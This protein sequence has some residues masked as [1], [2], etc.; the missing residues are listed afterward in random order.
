[1]PLIEITNE[2]SLPIKRKTRGGDPVGTVIASWSCP[3]GSMVMASSPILG[4]S[5]RVEGGFARLRPHQD[6]GQ[7]A[8]VSFTHP[9]AWGRPRVW[10]Y[11][12]STKGAHARAG[13]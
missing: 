1:M 11:Q 8:V 2:G 9:E 3:S 6:E 4:T 7:E 13:A 10:R 5:I 12:P